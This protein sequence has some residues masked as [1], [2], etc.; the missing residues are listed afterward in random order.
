MSYSQ[1]T[2]AAT[3]DGGHYNL[4]TALRTF[5]E[6]TLG[7]TLMRYSTDVGIVSSITKSGTTA[8]VTVP[9]GHD[10]VAGASITIAGASDGLYNGTFTIGGITT[11]TFTYTMS[12]T[13]AANAVGTLTATGSITDREVIWKAPGLSGT[14]QIYIGIK[15]YQN[16]STG[17]YNW[18]LNVFT[19]YLAGNAFSAQPG[20]VSYNISIPMWAQA[21]PYTFVGNGQRIIVAVNISGARY[22]I[23]L[24][25][26][27]PY[28]T[29][30]QW[31]YPV[32]V[33][34]ILVSD[35]ATLYSDTT[36]TSWFKGARNNFAMK[37]TSGAWRTPEILPF[38]GPGTK[39]LRNTK[40]DSNATEVAIPGYYGLHSLILSENVT[41]FINNYGELDG[42][43]YIT[44][45]SNAVDN[46]LVIAGITYLVLADNTRTG[47]K[48]YV[49]LRLA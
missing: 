39:V 24:G 9:E 4:L 13:P 36:Q 10:Q 26:F 19:G 38:G 3:G 48:D 15:T 43:Y 2:A 40:S 44:G 31:P 34:G 32:C 12:G 30:S 42:I 1:G 37:F 22:S 25:K 21:I 28:A 49:A 41:S 20:R 11:T 8:T 35:S 7:W 18:K 45:F 6:T 47:F 16:V 46:T 29:P 14:D 17:Y 5:C 23:Y 33:G 27:L